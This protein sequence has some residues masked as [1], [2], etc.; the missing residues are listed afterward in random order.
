[1]GAHVRE[2]VRLAPQRRLALVAIGH[3]HSHGAGVIGTLGREYD[4][5]LSP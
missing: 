2:I 4:N 3:R 1:M 5:D